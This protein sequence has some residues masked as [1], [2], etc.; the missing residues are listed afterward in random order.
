MSGDR[1]CDCDACAVVFRLIGPD[2]AASGDDDILDRL[3]HQW[4]GEYDPTGR[5][6]SEAA[7]EIKDLRAE[8][9]RY[10]ASACEWKDDYR[11]LIT[12]VHKWADAEDAAWGTESDTLEE[13]CHALRK[14]VGR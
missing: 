10:F 2:G 12:L 14:W 6:L 4:N 9:D 5:L 1:Q 7:D 3:R 8:R 13:A 11:T